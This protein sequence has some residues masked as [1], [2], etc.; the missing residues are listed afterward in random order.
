[1]EITFTELRN[2]EVINVLSGKSLG[3]I[4]DMVIDLRKNCVIGFI[5][6][7]SKSFLN[8]FGSKQDLFIPFCNICKVGEDVILV[9]IVETTN[10]KQKPIRVFDAGTGDEE[11][12]AKENN[13]KDK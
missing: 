3:N 11:Y 12:K 8:L 6:P 13:S 7:G 1:M 10:K 9:E 2:K 4:C 5:V